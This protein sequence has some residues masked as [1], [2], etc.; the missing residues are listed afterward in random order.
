MSEDKERKKIKLDR[1]ELISR[2]IPAAM[3][4]KRT[5]RIAL[6]LVLG[7]TIMV[8]SI[9]VVMTS[10][11]T[12]RFSSALKNQTAMLTNQLTT[13]IAVNLENFMDTIDANAQ[14]FFFDVGQYSYDPTLGLYSE[15]D[16]INIERDITNNLRMQAR[17]RRYL[18]Y[19]MAYEN[20]TT[21]GII[22]DSTRKDYGS[23]LYADMEKA[24]GEKSSVW[25]TGKA[26]DYNLVYYCTRVN[27]HGILIMSLYT[28]EV[29]SSVKAAIA[30]NGMTFYL[31]DRNY[32]VVYTSDEERKPGERLDV[33]IRN[34]ISR[35]GTRLDN[36]YMI[37]TATISN[38]WNIVMVTPAKRVLS[39]VNDTI[40]YVVIIAAILTVIFVVATIRMCIWIVSSMN[41]T[42]HT[43]DVKAQIDLLTGIYNKKSFE[44]VVNEELSGKKQKYVYAMVFMDVDNF[45]GV[46]DKCGHDIGDEVLK[47][48]ARSMGKAFR[49][50]DIKG[51]LG[52]D[53]F[54][55][56]MRVEK[57]HEGE[58]Q[59]QVESACGR[60]RDILHGMKNTNRQSLPAITSSMGVAIALPEDRTFEALYK[61]ADTALYESK[62]KGKDTWTVYGVFDKKGE[63]KYEV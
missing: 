27:E 34:R 2:F 6:S 1:E 13:Q 35:S 4:E 46:N 44:E 16:S 47:F 57:E 23:E 14:A 17:M 39:V 54:C 28:A 9:I 33:N 50:S 12:F 42:V 21:L 53:E 56:L 3:R 18:D 7:F 43:L 63:N 30:E 41:K 22:S 58:L 38:G 36:Q 52:G 49:N 29:M 20:G 5:S 55:V 61:K 59:I 32:T 60:F 10:F 24:L 62:K 11:V 45:K 25:T 15:Y 26:G 48:F 40:G 8:V 37:S 19:C 31:T 51:R